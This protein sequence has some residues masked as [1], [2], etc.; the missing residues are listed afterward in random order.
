SGGHACVIAAKQLAGGDGAA[1]RPASV[2]LSAPS[3][4]LRGRSK[5]MLRA[6]FGTEDATDP[7]VSPALCDVSFLDD[8]YV[9][10]RIADTTVA[11]SPELV[12][13]V[14][15]AGGTAELDE[16]LATHGVAQPSVQRARITDLAR[17][18]LA[19]TG[20]E[21]ELPAEAAGEYDKDAVD[22]ANEEN[23]GPRPGAG[24]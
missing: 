20:T 7:A 19:A 11:G 23:W 6:V 24:N 3:L 16:Y 13:K 22:R 9:Q 5:T 1:P 18:I 2:A 15:K 4:D 17:H 14:R 10:V 12:K 21:R 8:V